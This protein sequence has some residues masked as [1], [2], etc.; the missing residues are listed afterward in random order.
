MLVGVGPSS[1]LGGLP[2]QH[3]PLAGQGAQL[4]QSGGRRLLGRQ[5]PFQAQAAEQA[6]IELVGLALKL[7]AAGKI[8]YLIGK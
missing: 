1:E 8:L 4:A 5:R 3:L 6:R 2:Y 7:G